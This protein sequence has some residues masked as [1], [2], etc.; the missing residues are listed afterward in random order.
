[1]PSSSKRQILRGSGPLQRRATQLRDEVPGPS[2]LLESSGGWR[3]VVRWL[4]DGFQESRAND[5][6][7]AIAYYALLSVVP[8]ILGLVSI[9][10][11]VLRSD[12]GFSQAVDAVLWVV[13]EGLAE[14]GVSALGQLRDQSVAYGIASIAGFLWIGSTFFAALGRAMNQVYRV[15]DRSPLQQRLRGFAGVLVFSVLFTIAV[16]TAVVPTVVLGIDEGSMP[17]GL[18]R[19]RLFTGLYQLTS[20][21]VAV[22]VAILL[23]GVIFRVVPAAGQRVVDVVPGAVV[24]GLGFVLL[25]QVFPV[26]LRIVRNWNLIGGTAGL[27]SLVLVWFYILGHLF[28]FGAFINATWQRHRRGAGGADLADPV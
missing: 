23:F 4:V 28:L 16:V 25:V 7:A 10:G 11:V 18:E 21:V 3:G 2:E 20:Y 24:I 27:L 12:E 22:V 5:L 19:W 15:P 6:A 17:L 9:A 14:D 26:Y 1:M 13:P 8:I